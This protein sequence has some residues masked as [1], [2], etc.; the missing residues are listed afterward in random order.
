[1]PQVQPLPKNREKAR[2]LQCF[3]SSSKHT[4]MCMKLGDI[5]KR[6]VTYHENH[7]KHWIWVLMRQTHI[8]RNAFLTHST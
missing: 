4:D 8:G 1:M 5:S 7:M 2:V 3:R 6:Q